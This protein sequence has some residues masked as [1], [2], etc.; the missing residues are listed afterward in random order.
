MSKRKTLSVLLFLVFSLSFVCLL[1]S[2]RSKNYVNAVGTWNGTEWSSTT[3]GGTQVYTATGDINHV[4]KLEYST[5]L[6]SNNVIEFDVKMNSATND[7]PTRNFTVVVTANS[8]QTL[9]FQFMPQYFSMYIKWADKRMAG[10]NHDG[11]TMGAY[12]KATVKFEKNYAYFSFAGT[13]IEKTFTG[14]TDFSNA[15]VRFSAWGMLPSVK[16]IQLKSETIVKHSSAWYGA[17]TTNEEGGETI[18]TIND[19]SSDLQYLVSKNGCGATNTFS[20]GLRWALYDGNYDCDSFMVAFTNAYNVNL[21]FR[22]KPTFGAVYI[23]ENGEQKASGNYDTACNDDW[24]NVKI[25]F[26][27]NNAKISV[28]DILIAS[29]T[30]NVQNMSNASV[31][32]YTEDVYGHTDSFIVKVKNMDFYT[33]SQTGNA[34]TYDSALYS[35]PAENGHS[36]YQRNDSDVFAATTITYNRSL[37][38]RNAMT[39]A[40]KETGAII[41]DDTKNFGIHVYPDGTSGTFFEF[42]IMPVWDAVYILYY[43]NGGESQRLNAAN[44]QNPDGN[45]AAD[46][47]VYKD[48]KVIFDDDVLAIYVGGVLITN[49]FDTFGYTFN[50]PTVKIFSWGVKANFRGMTFLTEEIDF[51]KLGY[52]DLDFTDKRSMGAISVTGGNATYDATNKKVNIAFTGANPVINVKASTTEGDHYSAETSVRNTIL[53]RMKNATSATSVT[54]SV[55]T[56]KI[57]EWSSKNFTITPNQTKATNY[58][59][60]VSDLGLSGFLTEFKLAFNQAGGSVS[61]ET[62]SFE[63]EE[64]L[65]TFAAENYSLTANK[66]NKTV[67]FSGKLKSAYA[68]RTVTLY[69]TD[70][71]NIAEDLNYDN[72]VV[73]TTKANAS[74]NFSVT[75][76]LYN[77]DGYCHLTSIFMAA[78]DGIMLTRT[79]NIENWG[80]FVE[81]PYGFT[82]ANLTVNVTE[83]RFGALGDGYTNDNQAIQNAINYVS[84]QGGGKVVI[85]GDN[86]FYGRRFIVT[87]LEMKNNVELHIEKGAVLWQ[88]PRV[89]DYKYDVV[90]GHNVLNSGIMWNSANNKNRPLILFRNVTNGK[91]TGKGTIRME[92]N[93]AVEINPLNLID[94][95]YSKACWHT[96]HLSPVFVSQSKNIELRDFTIIRAQNWHITTNLA[97]NLFIGGVTLKHPTDS[98]SDGLGLTNARNVLLACNRLFG[99]DDS[100]TLNSVYADPRKAYDWNKPDVDGTRGTSNVEIAFNQLRGG[101]GLVFCPWSSGHK[102]LSVMV[103]KNIVVYNNILGGSVNQDIGAWTDNPFYGSSKGDNYILVDGENDDYSPIQD[104]YMFNN[105]YL[106]GNDKVALGIYDWKNRTVVTNLNTDAQLI[107]S[108]KFMNSS[109]EREYRYAGEE[110]WVSGL[111]YWTTVGK[112]IFGYEQVGTKTKTAKYKS[113]STATVKDYAGYISGA[114]T[115]YQGIYLKKGWYRITA[116]VKLTSGTASLFFGTSVMKQHATE[117]NDVNILRTKAIATNS[118]FTSNYFVFYAVQDGVYALGITA[119]VTGKVYFDDFVLESN[120][121]SSQQAEAAQLLRDG[122]Q[123]SVKQSKTLA[124][125]SNLYTVTSI[126]N[127][128]KYIGE[129]ETVLANQSATCESLSVSTDNLAYAVKALVEKPSTPSGGNS[130]SSSSSVTPKPDS[131]SSSSTTPKPSSS[132]SSENTTSKADS[133]VSSS[134]SSESESSISSTITPEPD[135][136]SSSVTPDSSDTS[137]SSVSPNK[138]GGCKASFS[139]AITLLLPLALLAVIILAKKSKKD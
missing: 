66:T 124:N 27:K 78:V 15:Y 76:P 132:S 24:L 89:S 90:I 62:V 36:V 125:K 86:S 38:T 21:E 45:E 87:N 136:P 56:T 55:K 35:N 6:G 50:N 30:Q 57:T 118:S 96:I 112:A 46:F 16:N 2:F 23:Y 138:I 79:F 107:G 110:T 85:P 95:N 120:V 70:V 39:F 74:G 108:T 105:V 139:S 14:G 99:N 1:V 135:T 37:S 77:V 88:S 25:V 60:N 114:G 33:E 32:I 3:E 67:T 49:Y 34:W 5:S 69:T 84:G 68:N 122:L 116:K 10:E 128:N 61:I 48:V 115:M 63:R 54:V 7:D 73:T 19:T 4:H 58:Y 134:V 9:K 104:I 113:S 44:Y 93:G 20:F 43:K 103:T 47:G 131:S 40:F 18:Y 64:S 102:D 100:I 72:K 53:V 51:L 80:D 111:S 127:L 28:N 123:K 8:G 94:P 31:S 75:F 11:I 137:S 52:I 17:A 12:N 41:N 81:N 42:C 119:N 97:E 98:N 65:Y 129:A 26:A 121:T 106:H 22:I 92:D 82:T 133:S 109:F 130:G 83:S 91:L 29:T 126:S 13:S 101:L 59:F 117:A 71:S